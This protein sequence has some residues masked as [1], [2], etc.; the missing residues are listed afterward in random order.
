LSLAE[1]PQ[2]EVGGDEH[3]LP[4]HIEEDEVDGHEYAREPGTHREDQAQEP[5]R[6]PHRDW[7]REHGDN[8]QKGVEDDQPDADSVDAEVVEDR[9]LRYPGSLLR[10]LVLMCRGVERRS[11]ADRNA[12]G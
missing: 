4:E 10:E 3:R 11:D 12:Q 6:V 1:L 9:E 8:R 7:S 5:V 2:Q